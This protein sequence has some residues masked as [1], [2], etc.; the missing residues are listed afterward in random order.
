VPGDAAPLPPGADPNDADLDFTGSVMPPPPA[1]PLSEDDKRLFVRWIDLGAPI[2]TG[3]PDYGWGLDDLRPTLT[4]SAPRPGLNRQHLQEIRLGVADAHSGIAP[5]SLSLRA[6]VVLAGRAAGSELADLL[7]EVAQGIWSLPLP[8]ALARL[9]EA[10]LHASVRDRQGNIT[11]V[12]VRFSTQLG[13][14]DLIRDGF[15]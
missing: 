9:Q 3:N 13:P 6:D 2:D 12:S 8:V 7:S 14:D 5:G 1:L 11:R 4:V 10:N 15:E